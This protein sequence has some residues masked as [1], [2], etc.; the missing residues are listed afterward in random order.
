MTIRSTGIYLA[1]MLT[2]VSFSIFQSCSST[3]QP[4]PAKSSIDVSF[5]G[6]PAV[7]ISFDDLFKLPRITIKVGE[8]DENGPSLF[9]LFELL[10]TSLNVTLS[11]LK[12]G[13]VTVFGNYKNQT[14]ISRFTFGPPEMNETIILNISKQGVITFFGPSISSTYWTFEVS[15]LL[16]EPS[17]E[18]I[19]G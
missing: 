18:E 1:T 7:V 16:V 9:A 10:A 13:Q 14:S 6:G 11:E 12:L 5:N 4:T 2:L 8:N 17:D 15:G 3:L 19:Y